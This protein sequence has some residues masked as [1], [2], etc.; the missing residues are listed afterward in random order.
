MAHAPSIELE[1]PDAAT[2]ND[3]I[4]TLVHQLPELEGKEAQLKIAVGEEYVDNTTVLE[5]NREIAVFPPVSGG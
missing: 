3:L 5:T 4:K 2:G 1:L